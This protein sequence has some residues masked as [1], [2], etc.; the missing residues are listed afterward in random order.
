MLKHN[1]KIIKIILAD[2]DPDDRSFF[3]EAIKQLDFDSKVVTVENGKELLDYLE[4]EETDIP[5]IVFLDLNMP[6]LNGLETLKR[7]KQQQKYNNI[8]VAIYST[9]SA[10]KDIENTLANGANCYIVKP[11]DFQNLKSTLKYVLSL[12]WQYHTSNGL[13]LSNFVISV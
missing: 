8:A 11:N 3:E 7:L 10:N 1:Q 13:D 5:H 6:I 2:D 9:S 12:Q 4:S